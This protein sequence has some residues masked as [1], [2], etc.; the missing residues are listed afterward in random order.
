M[1]KKVRVFMFGDYDFLLKMYGISGA[2]SYHPCLWCKAS[3][4]QTQR[5][6]QIQQA[7]VSK[8]TVENIKR[9]HRKYFLAGNKKTFNNVVFYP[10]W[11]IKLTQVTPPYLQL[12]L[13]IVKKHHDLLE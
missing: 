7:N 11:D 5:Q 3:R 2:Q 12:N 10:V 1:E 13:G 6:R 4:H 9:D 8:R